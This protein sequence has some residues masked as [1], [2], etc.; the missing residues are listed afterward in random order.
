MQNGDSLGSQLGLRGWRRP[1]HS[2]GPEDPVSPTKA[3]SIPPREG[4][5]D[6]AE[7]PQGRQSGPQN[8]Q[9]YLT[10]T[11]SL[12]QPNLTLNCAQGAL[13]PPLYPGAH[14]RLDTA[15]TPTLTP[16]LTP[17]QLYPKSTLLHIWVLPC[18][19]ALPRPP[20]ALTCAHPQSRLLPKTATSALLL[21]QTHNTP[22]APAFPGPALILI[23]SPCP[24]STLLPVSTLTT[25]PTLSAPGSPQTHFNPKCS[26]CAHQVST[27]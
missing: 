11:E 7:T 14:P 25:K 22:P 8:P 27:V 26:C 24:R 12:V 4:K 17:T 23:P 1:H 20:P 2:L 5:T 9:P 3:E 21:P 19:Q 6:P 16:N 15:L 13:C 18:A 10:L